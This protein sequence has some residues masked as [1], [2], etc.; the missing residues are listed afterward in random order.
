MIALEKMLADLQK[1]LKDI[2]S[3]SSVWNEC[4]FAKKYEID[5][6]AVNKKKLIVYVPSGIIKKD[7]EMNSEAMLRELNGKI[8]SRKAVLTIEVKVRRR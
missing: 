2:R 4:S 5:E 3:V 7:I 8:S 1:K 6:F